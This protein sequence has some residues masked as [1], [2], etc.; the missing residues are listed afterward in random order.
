MSDQSL[1][2]RP[3]VESGGPAGTAAPFVS[4][5]APVAGAEGRRPAAESLADR[6]LPFAG[7]AGAAAGA[8]AGAVAGV[9]AGTAFPELC[10]ALGTML[11]SGIA[12]VGWCGVAGLCER[13]ANRER[14]H[15]PVAPTG[16]W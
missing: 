6:G 16:G 3:R 8:I 14:E 13:R 11:G 7:I 5:T 1:Q 2:T 15:L 10:G 12:A 4:G 9:A